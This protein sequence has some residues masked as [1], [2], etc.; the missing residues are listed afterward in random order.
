[1]TVYHES[2]DVNV[3]RW[4][5]WNHTGTCSLT[6]VRFNDLISPWGIELRNEIL[7]KPLHWLEY[8]RK[9]WKQEPGCVEGEVE[10]GGSQ[11]WWREGRSHRSSSW[12][13]HRIEGVVFNCLGLKDQDKPIIGARR[14][15]DTEW[16][17]NHRMKEK[18]WLM[19]GTWM[20]LK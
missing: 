6:D 10:P 14:R 11:W 18:T 19:V 8:W 7:T 12:R 16:W 13:S 15:N 17:S 1:M 3:T 4:W 9:K 5:H 20:Y 2:E